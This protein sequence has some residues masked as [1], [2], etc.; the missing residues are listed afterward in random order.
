MLAEVKELAETQALQE[1]ESARRGRGRY[2][3]A[4]SDSEEAGVGL[5]AEERNQIE[6]ERAET[7]RFMKMTQN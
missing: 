2:A 4:S 5:S 7:E 3:D 6:T 1:Q